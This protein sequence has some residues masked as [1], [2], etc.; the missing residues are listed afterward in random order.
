MCWQAL[1]SKFTSNTDQVLGSF[2]YWV[3]KGTAPFHTIHPCKAG[4]GLVA[5]GFQSAARSQILDAGFEKAL[6]NSAFNAVLAWHQLNN[7]MHV[8]FTQNHY[9]CP[10]YLVLSLVLDTSQKMKI[11]QERV[12]SEPGKSAQRPRPSSCREEHTAPDPHWRHQTLL[13]LPVHR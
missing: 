12:L 7:V 2:R 6:G 4:K 9:T 8:A 13:L 11:P 10:G 3:R 5:C 1:S